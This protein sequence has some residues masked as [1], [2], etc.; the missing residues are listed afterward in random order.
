[1]GGEESKACPF[2]G[3]TRLSSRRIW[4]N[5]RFIVCL[6][7]NACGPMGLTPEDARIRWNKRVNLDSPEPEQGSLFWEG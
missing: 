3:S 6:K 4:G 7:C 5:R 2:C 1:M